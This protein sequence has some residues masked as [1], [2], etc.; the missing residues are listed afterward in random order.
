[1]SAQSEIFALR[2]EEEAIERANVRLERLQR[3][4]S[5]KHP[6]HLVVFNMMPP[7]TWARLPAMWQSSRELRLSPQAG[8]PP[9]AA[10][11][12]IAVAIDVAERLII[13]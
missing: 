2:R 6:A 4:L 8:Y 9:R 1:V 3:E 13:V 11:G 7:G 10:K 5:F 12:A